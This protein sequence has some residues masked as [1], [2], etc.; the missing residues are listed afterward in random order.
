M[1]ASGFVVYNL[2]HLLSSP[3]V[4][5]CFPD[6]AHDLGQFVHGEGDRA[7]EALRTRDQDRHSNSARHERV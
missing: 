6:S 7:L 1:L 3:S 4:V 5:E 2:R